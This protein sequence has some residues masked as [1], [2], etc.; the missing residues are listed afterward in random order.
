ME[1][2]GDIVPPHEKLQQLKRL[3]GVDIV[4]GGDRP[5]Q[6]GS[7]ALVPFLGRGTHTVIL[8]E[9]VDV[10]PLGRGQVGHSHG[11]SGLV[12]KGIADGGRASGG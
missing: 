6:D 11:A 5:A 8:K 10:E 2:T 1:I 12:G 4:G 9:A 3:G 7:E